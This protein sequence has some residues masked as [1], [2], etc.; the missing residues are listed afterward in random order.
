MLESEEERERYSL[1]EEYNP[2][3][4]SEYIFKGKAFKA[5]KKYI[6][7]EYAARGISIL[8]GFSYGNS[9]YVL[10]VD[11]EDFVKEI[12]AW[13]SKE[14][15]KATDAFVTDIPHDMEY[16]RHLQELFENYGED[17]TQD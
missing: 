10:S 5:F 3:R 13:K 1:L 11:R 8:E 7:F 6:L 14:Q 4:I 12:I 9:C 16:S 15:V 17:N 2:S